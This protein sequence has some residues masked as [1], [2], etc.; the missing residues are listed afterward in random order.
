MSTKLW[1]IIYE[2]YFPLGNTLFENST[3]KIIKL[4]KNNRILIFIEIGKLGFIFSLKF[5]LYIV[6][7]IKANIHFNINIYAKTHLFTIFIYRSISF[8]I[9]IWFH[10]VSINRL[11]FLGWPYIKRHSTNRVQ[12]NI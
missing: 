12:S 7:T 10:I 4:T 3:S 9:Y 11:F 5:Y 2:F 8:Y 6:R 1:R